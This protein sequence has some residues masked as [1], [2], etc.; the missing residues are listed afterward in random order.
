MK[1]FS[2][3]KAAAAMAAAALVCLSLSGC[4][5]FRP[6]DG[7]ESDDTLET[8]HSTTLPEQTT[9]TQ[10]KPETTPS[11]TTE[12][13][14]TSTPV[15]TPPKPQEKRVSVLAVGDNIIHEAVYVD[16]AKRAADGVKYDF[17]PMYSGVADEIAAADIAFIN[18]ESPLAG[19]NY[20]ISGYPTFNSPREAGQALVDAG[21]DVINLANNH[22][23]DKKIAGA[24]AT[25]EYV[26]SLPV[27]EL[28]VYLDK[29]DYENIR[30][31]EVNGIRIGWVSFCAESNN[32]YNPSSADIIMPLMNDDSA[33]AERIKAA[34]SASDFVIVS[35]HW[36]KDGAA[37]ITAEQKRLAKIMADAGADV[38]LGHHPHILQSVEWVT[39]SSGKK[40]LTAYSLGNFLSSQLYAN[41]MVGGMLTFDVVM[42]DS[43][44]CKL[45]K[46]VMNIAVNHYSGKKDASQ[47]YG[48]YRYGMQLYMLEDYTPALAADHGCRFFSEGFSKD[49]IEKHVR[50]IIAEEF[51][52]AYFE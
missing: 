46:A 25:V 18:H 42:D 15:T 44:N 45:E 31:T 40:T 23:L 37:Q 16:A 28:G 50:S 7:V 5:M 19:E 30:V 49:W 51:L 43:G 4:S 9:D 33:I 11:A 22:I 6:A 13:P 39:S 32:P 3:C 12:P 48:V 34:D 29:K 35:A 52:P 36:G 2:I 27:T 47:D 38:I 1:H 14:V 10:K 17:L 24:R 8:N 26:Q 41:N 20:G 21:F